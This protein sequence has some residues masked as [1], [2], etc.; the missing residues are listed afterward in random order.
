MINTLFNRTLKDP[1]PINVNSFY[2][3][4]ERFVNNGSPSGYAIDVPKKYSPINDAIGAI[5]LGVFYDDWHKHICTGE[6]PT[7]IGLNTP[8]DKVPI[9]VHPRMIEEK[10]IPF[11]SIVEYIEAIPTASARTFFCATNSDKPFFIKCHY[12]WNVGRFKRDMPL[13]KWISSLERSK[14][15]YKYQD[16]LPKNSAF[17]YETSGIFYQGETSKDSFGYIFR[18]FNISPVI[19]HQYIIIPAF[20][21]FANIN[22]EGNQYCLIDLLM[23]AFEL[24]NMDVVEL[25]VF[26]VIDAFIFLSTKLGLV[27]ECNAQNVLYEI[28][29]TTGSVRTVVRDFEDFFIDKSIRRENNFHTSFCSYKVI[30]TC[31]N[32]F[33]ER[34]SF[35]YDFK[36]SYY[37]V[38][39]ILESISKGDDE[40]LC[41]LKEIVKSYAKNKFGDYFKEQDTWYAYPNKTE[42][43]R[44]SYVER[45]N[46]LFR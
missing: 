46:P 39:P 45:N 9:I 33:Y 8:I 3:Y 21:L 12:P 41:K 40:I 1:S 11:S 25:F 32:D 37:L 22:H 13:F 4:L 16:S 30:D 29:L 38:L 26:S 24:S 7:Q 18:D 17:L 5:K 2:I 43:D 15:L 35:A 31:G 14:E 23:D 27:P 28:S 19:D 36:L 6:I 44:G 34:R 42:V 20:S 10:M